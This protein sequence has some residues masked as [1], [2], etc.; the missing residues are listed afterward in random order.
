MLVISHYETEVFIKVNFLYQKIYHITAQYIAWIIE[1]NQFWQLL[2][3]S[4]GAESPCDSDWQ[5]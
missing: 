1:R 4:L 2:A 3:T 5:G